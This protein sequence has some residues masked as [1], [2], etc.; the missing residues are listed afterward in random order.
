MKTA[1]AWGSH[2]V[3]TFDAETG[4]VLS[5]STNPYEI[6]GG[7]QPGDPG[8]NDIVWIDIF[9]WH[10]HYPGEVLDSVDILDVGYV[11]K[12]GHYEHPE[13]DWRNEFNS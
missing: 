5:V 11:T 4:R 2:G 10:R 9:E 12:D 7:C 3:I 8:Y 1:E 13:Q 6:P